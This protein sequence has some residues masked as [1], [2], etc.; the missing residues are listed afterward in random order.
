MADA[1]A[2]A[3]QGAGMTP[4][5]VLQQGFTPEVF[6]AMR[7]I[8]HG[9]EQRFQAVESTVVT[10]QQFQRSIE[11]AFTHTNLTIAAPPTQQRSSSPKDNFTKLVV[12]PFSGK[13][14][15]NVAAWIALAEDALDTGK[16]PTCRD[17]AVR[18]DL[19]PL[20]EALQRLY[21][22]LHPRETPQRTLG[23]ALTLRP[24]QLGRGA[25]TLFLRVP[26]PAGL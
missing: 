21:P 16:V 20:R 18:P 5:E 17:A 9:F 12:Q 4:I 1:N 25:P 24:D 14:S 26:Y 13:T 3:G 19:E 15:D 11:T 8:F 22:H 10:S 6:Q 23:L 2:P 7:V